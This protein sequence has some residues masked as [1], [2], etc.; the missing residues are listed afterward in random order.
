MK[1]VYICS[2]LRG[3]YEQNI[4][5]TAEF[6]RAAVKCGYMPIAP[7][8]YFPQFL[9]DTNAEEREIGINY[10]LQLLTDCDEMWVFLPDSGKP[11][12]GMRQEI[13]K[14]EE[15]NKSYMSFDISEALELIKTGDFIA[16]IT[17]INDLKKRGGE[18]CELQEKRGGLSFKACR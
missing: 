9:N 16:A 2:P 5:N 4:K 15:V 11:S 3:N 1:K 14:A 18:H 6:C 8:L 7:H 12:D 13:E 17:T 10:G